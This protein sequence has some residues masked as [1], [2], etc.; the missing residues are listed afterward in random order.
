MSAAQ[1]PEDSGAADEQNGYKDDPASLGIRVASLGFDAASLGFDSASLGIAEARHDFEEL[2]RHLICE[3]VQ[4]GASEDEVVGGGV[5]AVLRE[6][7]HFHLLVVCV[8]E[9]A[10]AGSVPSSSH[11]LRNADYGLGETPMSAS[12]LSALSAGD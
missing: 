12:K 11:D 10:A 4:A 6:S 8:V 5:Y 2:R 3:D 1:N 9:M 7:T